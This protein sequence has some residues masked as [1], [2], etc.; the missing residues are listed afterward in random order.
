MKQNMPE[1]P[2]PPPTHAEPMRRKTPDPSL[3]ISYR[4]HFKRPGPQ[5]DGGAL[6]LT[7]GAPQWRTT[8]SRQ[9]PPAVFAGPAP[10]RTVGLA[11]GPACGG[12]CPLIT[13]LVRRF[14]TLCSA[15]SC[16]LA[17]ADGTRYGPTGS[18]EPPPRRCPP[19]KVRHPKLAY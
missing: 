3:Q 14:A 13:L 10:P 11:I 18:L 16:P 5:A 12:R 9:T 1:T 8:P 19:R 6:F 7:S 2:R 15:S 4:A 17:T